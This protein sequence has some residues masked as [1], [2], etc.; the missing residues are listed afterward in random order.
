VVDYLRIQGMMHPRGLF[1]EPTPCNC[2][3][4]SAPTACVADLGFAGE[5]S[6]CCSCPANRCI[7]LAC[8]PPDADS[9]LRTASG[10]GYAEQKLFASLRLD[11][12]QDRLYEWQ[13]LGWLHPDLEARI[14]AANPSWQAE[15]IPAK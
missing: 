2:S 4:H 1:G 11:S 10:A 8:W 14:L 6:S 5:C 15:L 3:Q 13:Q 7:L 12:P 9:S